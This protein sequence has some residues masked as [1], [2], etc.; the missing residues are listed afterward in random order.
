[1][2]VSP[3]H[4]RK[5]V[6]EELGRVRQSQWRDPLLTGV[7]TLVLI[8]GMQQVDKVIYGNQKAE[9]Q[10]RA[11]KAK[12]VER[13]QKEALR[14][15]YEETGGADLSRVV[16]S[17]T[18]LFTITRKSATLA[19]SQE[20]ILGRVIGRVSKETGCPSVITSVVWK[21]DALRMPWDA[22]KPTI[23][24]AASVCPK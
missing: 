3:E 22:P 11:D 24:S 9:V 8:I 23:Y 4:I 10:E 6:R 17:D 16:N 15:D 13:L 14:R 5:L 12:E 19:G 2:S 18:Y 7:G 20:E 1:M 21:D